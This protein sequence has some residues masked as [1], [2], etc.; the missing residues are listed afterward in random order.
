MK[1]LHNENLE[2]T[3]RTWGQHLRG[4]LESTH[5]AFS[6]LVKWL[7]PKSDSHAS[8]RLFERPAPRN[9]DESMRR[10]WNDFSAR[11]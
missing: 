1:A 8:G 6:L 10:A 3:F 7:G 4:W 11:R 9:D 5:T 2:A